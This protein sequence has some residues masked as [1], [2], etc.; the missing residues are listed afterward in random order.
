MEEEKEER[1][2]IYLL[3]LGEVGDEE[4]GD[5]VLC[6]LEIP[7]GV[8]QAGVHLGDGGL[9]QCKISI[10]VY[11]QKYISL[12]VHKSGHEDMEGC[13]SPCPLAASS[14]SRSSGW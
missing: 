9:K 14:L 12:R 3:H 1:R 5:A 10:K 11:L 8:L 13:S 6:V 4:G 7:A 2:R